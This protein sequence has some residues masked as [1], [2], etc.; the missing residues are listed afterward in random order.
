M[1]ITVHI[2]VQGSNAHATITIL[3]DKGNIEYDATYRKCTIVAK[4]AS[5]CCDNG[6]AKEWNT[7]VAPNTYEYY[8]VFVLRVE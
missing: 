2:V 7:S 1:K 6:E 3:A 5:I 8:D 4:N